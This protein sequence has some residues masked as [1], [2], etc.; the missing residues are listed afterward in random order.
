MHKSLTWKEHI[1]YINMK[2]AKNI[3]IL[4]KMRYFT[5]QDTLCSIYNAFILP[6]VNYCTINWGGASAT[7]LDPLSKSLK[8]AAR[9]IFFE[10]QTARSRPLFKKLK[11]L[12]IEDTYYEECTKFMFD[13][14]KGRC[15]D[16][17]SNNFQLSKDRH[18]KQTRQ[19]TSGKF[20]FTKT[21]TKHKLNFITTSGVK[22]GTISPSIRGT[23]LQKN[24]LVNVTSKYYWI[25]TD[26]RIYPMEK[27]NDPFLYFSAFIFI[28]P[29]YCC[30]HYT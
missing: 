19:A 5:P 18:N 26:R 29:S 9:I 14:S 1:Q 27:E 2:L 24:Y 21:R 15:E 17:F 23:L 7:V 22:N 13:I 20:S 28:C 30:L 8:K 25:S 11:S 4:A 10:K 16:F 6:Y 12:T 3:F